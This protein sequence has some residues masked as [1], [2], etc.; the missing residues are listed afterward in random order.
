MVAII[1]YA[2]IA[3]TFALT[4]TVL[5]L[6]QDKQ[7]LKRHSFAMMGLSAAVVIGT[8]FAL[9]ATVLWMLL[10]L[11]VCLM[12]ICLWAVSGFKAQGLRFYL[13]HIGM[14][15]MIIGG[16]MLDWVGP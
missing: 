4:Y 6:I 14:V 13:N 8:A 11:W 2:A 7:A 5:L 10:L 3:V 16:D 1:A 9:G 12:P 15:L